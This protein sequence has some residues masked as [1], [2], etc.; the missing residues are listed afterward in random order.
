MKKQ[1]ILIPLMILILN[2]CGP[3]KMNVYNGTFEARKLPRIHG[4]QNQLKQNE[5][6]KIAIEG[7][8]GNNQTIRLQNIEN[9]YYKGEEYELKSSQADISY[10]VINTTGGIDFSKRIK[11]ELG[12]YGAG[13]GAQPYPYIYAVFGINHTNLEIGSH[14]LIGVSNDKASYSGEV[15]WIK[16]QIAG[17]WEER[18]TF[19]NPS[20]T[21]IHTYTAASFFG[22]AYM[23]G[24]SINYVGTI[25]WPWGLLDELSAST[26]DGE[27]SDFD[28][29]FT[30]P[31]MLIN[32]ISL[33]YRF[34]NISLNIG[35]NIIVGQN[36][37]GRYN[38]IG[39][40]LGY[41]Y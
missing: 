13:I 30:M 15:I 9:E 1:I 33:G 10:R 24:I 31:Y 34:K 25:G 18:E 29:S 37:Q 5:N 3:S 35:Y 36:F 8:Y 19:E 7:N 27:N 17:S 14:L 16:N 32:D 2:G 28:I 12:F 6:Y 20:T 38:S 23:Y 11:K 41:N 4:N 22:S 40:S 26:S 39:G 21:I